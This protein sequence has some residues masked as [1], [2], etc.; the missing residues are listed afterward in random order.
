[1]LNKRLLIG[2]AILMVLNACQTN[3]KKIKGEI[4]ALLQ[5]SK[6]QV[7]QQITCYTKYISYT[8]VKDVVDFKE[9]DTAE[10]NTLINEI[11][12]LNL[13]NITR[14]K[15]Y[16]LVEKNSELNYKTQIKKNLIKELTISKNDSQINK[17]YVVKILDNEL[18]LIE[19]K[20]TID[21]KDNSIASIDV[22]TEQK[23]LG[24]KE[25]D[26]YQLN[27]KRK[28]PCNSTP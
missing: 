25:N 11:A 4:D 16:K 27:I 28:E 14:N 10:V 1:M 17:I 6:Q 7:N 3:T 8:D 12:G 21:F 19:K 9:D 24:R 13:D 5:S 23:I 2:F 15:D 22:A 18:F 26:N 20:Y